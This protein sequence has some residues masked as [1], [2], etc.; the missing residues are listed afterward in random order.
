M[1]VENAALIGI[2][3]VARSGKDT[4]YE[5]IQEWMF[6]FNVLTQRVALADELKKS[7]SQPLEDIGIDV[8]T[9]DSE[10]KSLIRPFLVS[11]G[12]IARVSTEGTHWTSKVQTHI[13]NLMHKGIVPVVTDIRYAEF[14]KDELYWVKQNGGILIHVSRYDIGEYGEKRW[15]M[16]PNEDE[17]INDPL[18]RE[19][20]D[21][22]IEWPTL[23]DRES[24][25]EFAFKEFNEGFDGL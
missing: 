23:G 2:A 6:G 21:F 8:W 1:R 22:R 17:A 20:A 13:T 18:L 19:A 25:K 9:S 12:R 16:P 3:G 5:C 11:Y 15:I 14:T 4:L 7:L 24:I 10:T